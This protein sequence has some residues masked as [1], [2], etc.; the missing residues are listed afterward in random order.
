MGSAPATVAL[1]PQRIRLAQPTTLLGAELPGFGK[2]GSSAGILIPR[3]RLL[4]Y[5]MVW[6]G[7]S[8]AADTSGALITAKIGTQNQ[9]ICVDFIREFRNPYS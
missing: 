5:P 6:S 8:W 1:R 3:R 9:Q 2:A 7:N 4:Y